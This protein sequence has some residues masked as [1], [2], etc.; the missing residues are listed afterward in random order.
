MWLAASMVITWANVIAHI[1]GRN[2]PVWMAN[3][4]LVLRAG[5]VLSSCLSAD[6]PRRQAKKE[7]KMSRYILFPKDCQIGR[8]QRIKA[9]LTLL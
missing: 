4:C 2:Q 6:I 8:K 1:K 3:V 9:E 5:I 7:T